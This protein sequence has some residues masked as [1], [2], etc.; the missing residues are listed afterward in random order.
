MLGGRARED[1][2]GRGEGDL[3][4]HILAA[5]LGEEAVHVALEGDGGAVADAAGAGHLHRLADVEGEVRRRHQAEPQFARMERHRHVMPGEGAD[6]AHVHAVVAKRNA[7]VLR[8]HI[9]EARHDTGCRP[10]EGGGMGGLD[11]TS[12]GGALRFTAR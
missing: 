3:H 11:E 12:A 9:I 4:R 2:V 6:P 7:V 1:H 8:P 5:H 10:D